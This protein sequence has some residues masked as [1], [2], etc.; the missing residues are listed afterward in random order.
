MDHTLHDAEHQLALHL[1]K[2]A[3]KA[4][5]AAQKQAQLPPQNA[6]VPSSAS[7]NGGTIAGVG[8]K[9]NPHMQ[10]HPQPNHPQ[11]PPVQDLPLPL[12][13]YGNYIQE[14]PYNHPFPAAAADT[15]AAGAES[16]GTVFSEDL[17]PGHRH[18]SGLHW[19]YPNTFLPYTPH[20]PPIA[21]PDYSHLPADA[22]RPTLVLDGRMSEDIVPY[23]ALKRAAYHTLLTKVER[24]G[25]HTGWSAV[26]EAALF[27][28]LHQPT[29][30]LNALS[31]FITRFVTA[32]LMCL[33]PPLDAKNEVQCGTCFGESPGLVFDRRNTK[34][35][36]TQE[37]IVRLREVS[38]GIAKPVISAHEL[39]AL[40]DVT[41]QPRGMVT[42]QPFSSKVIR[43]SFILFINLHITE[44]LFS[45]AHYSSRS[46][47]I[48]AT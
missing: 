43:C 8:S 18:F 42:E 16:P 45:L 26:W 20:P 28:R 2:A 19:L 3:Q 46:T 23:Y 47:A 6:V 21:R 30:A 14:Y 13:E 39:S 9:L 31:K 17:D 15:I 37:T 4:Q 25:G 24:G 35:K 36:D 32:N 38:K 12:P 40:Q 41:P 34:E 1:A 27:A 33:H 22:K 29:Y 11:V 10:H 44:L 48:L 5:I 7:A